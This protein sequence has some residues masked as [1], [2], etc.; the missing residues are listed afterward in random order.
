MKMSNIV[1]GTPRN[2]QPGDQVM[3]MT[4]AH[5]SVEGVEYQRGTEYTP[6]AA[7]GNNLTGR[8]EQIAMIGAERVTFAAR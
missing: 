2:A 6:I 1:N 5:V 8:R 4:R 7:G 3:V